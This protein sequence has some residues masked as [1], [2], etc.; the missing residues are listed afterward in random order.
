LFD[1]N[2]YLFLLVRIENLVFS[3]DQRIPTC[4]IFFP[5]WFEQ[6]FANSQWFEMKSSNIFNWREKCFSFDWNGGRKF[7]LLDWC[8]QFHLQ[9]WIGFVFLFKSQLVQIKIKTLSS[10]FFARFFPRNF[11]IS[12]SSV[13]FRNFFYFGRKK[14]SPKEISLIK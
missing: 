3:L 7:Q 5:K 8:F 6:D 2:K 9:I 13:F 14:V 12:N 10:S 4:F 11:D 1:R